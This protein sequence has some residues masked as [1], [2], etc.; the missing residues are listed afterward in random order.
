[1]SN[2]PGPQHYAPPIATDLNVWTRHDAAHAL[3]GLDAPTRGNAI[4]DLL[5]AEPTADQ[6][7]KALAEDMLTA[8]DAAAW[9]EDALDQI[10]RAHAADALR[11]AIGR[12]RDAVVRAHADR[13][14]ADA[15]AAVAPAFDRT[16]KALTRA[17]AKLPAGDRPL[18][19][20]PVVAL[21]ATKEMKSAQAALRDLATLAGIHRTPNAAGLPSRVVR[22]V[23]VV[24]FPEVPVETVDQMT[25]AP[26]DHHAGRDAVRR[27]IRDADERGAD[28][29]L[30]GVARGEYDGLTL[31]L[32]ESTADLY[33]NANRAHAAVARRK[34]ERGAVRVA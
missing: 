18:D 20:E 27:F 7:A 4:T 32:A 14:T 16:A 9:L 1:M 25:G 24:D 6:T 11:H 3:A 2:N 21:D 29:A 33:D 26:L 23:A 22:L 15:A 12:H 13:L 17:A 19:L 5:N 34:A 31:R 10:K 8:P 28:R 30:I